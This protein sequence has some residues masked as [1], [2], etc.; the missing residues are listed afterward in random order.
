MLRDWIKKPNLPKLYI[1]SGLLSRCISRWT[2]RAL[3]IHSN[4]VHQRFL[5]VSCKLHIES[6]KDLKK[7]QKHKENCH[8]VSHTVSHSRILW[9]KHRRSHASNWWPTLSLEP[10]PPWDSRAAVARYDLQFWRYQPCVD[11]CKCTTKKQLQTAWRDPSVL[12]KLKGT[13][14][15]WNVYKRVQDSVW[16]Y[17]IWMLF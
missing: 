1:V 8:W 11:S 2:Q 9:H 7:P 5:H 10:Q 16:Y 4:H 14:C 15:N 12:S 3:F 17:Q 13:Q 6:L